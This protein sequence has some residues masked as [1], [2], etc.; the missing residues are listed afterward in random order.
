MNFRLVVSSKLLLLMFVIVSLGTVALAADQTI[1]TIT[2]DSSNRTYK[3]V[4]DTS[5]DDHKIKNFYKD[6]YEEGKKINRENLNTDILVK[7]GV[8]LEQRKKF[9]IM[10]LKSNSFDLD[11][12]GIVTI[13]TL[14][15][16]VTDQRREY[17]LQIA[18]SSS[19]W[20]LFQ[21]N[22]IINTIQIQTN[23]VSIIGE[24]GIKNLIMKFN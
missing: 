11:Q 1:A 4:I 8:I 3:L 13:D 20:S 6:T 19:G 9:V 16:G 18:Q 5:E 24:V 14:Y 7:T 15:N 2:T 17:D 21:K 23:R 22:K 12:G 10:K